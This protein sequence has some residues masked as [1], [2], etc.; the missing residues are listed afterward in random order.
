MTAGSTNRGQVS[1]SPIGVMPPYS[2]PLS[3][4]AVSI[5]ANDALR[6]PSEFV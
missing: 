4:T 5:D 1:G 6:A 3:P 2:M